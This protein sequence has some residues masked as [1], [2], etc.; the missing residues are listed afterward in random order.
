MRRGESVHPVN[1]YVKS[2]NLIDDFHRNSF[3]GSLNSMMFF[4]VVWYSSFKLTQSNYRYIKTKV[5][6]LPEHENHD[7]DKS[8]LYFLKIL[9]NPNF[10]LI[11]LLCNQVYLLPCFIFVHENCHA[12]LMHG[13]APRWGESVHANFLQKMLIIS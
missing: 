9:R 5:E 4:D 6:I 10:A 8:I 11:L 7:C 12:N 13:F 3:I 1:L 2:P